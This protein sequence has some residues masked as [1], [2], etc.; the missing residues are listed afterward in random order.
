LHIALQSNI[1]Y[2]GVTSSSYEQSPC[3]G[4]CKHKEKQS[5]LLPEQQRSCF[6]SSALQSTFWRVA[7]LHHLAPQGVTPSCAARPFRPLDAG[8]SFNQQARSVG[9]MQY[10]AFACRSLCCL[11][12]QGAAA[13]RAAP[14]PPLCQPAHRHRCTARTCGV[15]GVHAKPAND[16]TTL[17]RPM[18]NPWLFLSVPS[19]RHAVPL[20]LPNC[21]IAATSH[22]WRATVLLGP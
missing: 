5:P 17:H 1:F 10:V 3:A 9:A 22:M 21:G 15:V 16:F 8:P 12:Q 18:P 7:P 19:F 4:G 20:A 13:Q 2:S 6:I 11:C 14:P